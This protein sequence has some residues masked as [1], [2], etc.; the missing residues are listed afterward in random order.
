MSENTKGMDVEQIIEP[1][2]GTPVVRDVDVLVCGGGV[3]GVG[4]ALGAA[5]AGAKTMV[6]ERNAFLGGAATAVIMNT[7]NVPFHKMTGVAKEIAGALTE[8]G[9]GVVSGPTFPFDPEGFK[10]L[11]A[12]LFKAEGIEIL[13]YS[14]V[15]D[16]IMKD[17]QIRGVIIQNKSGRQAILAKTVVDAT[18]DADIAA[19]AGA[20]FV[21]GRENDAKMRPM[22]VLFRLGGVDVRRAVEFCRQNP[23]NFTADPNFH[24]LDLDTGLVRMS[25]FFDI[26]DKARANGELP[27]EIH[28]IR[29]EGVSVDR[30]IVTVNNSRVYGVDGTSGWDLTRA[31]IEARA[32]NRQLFAVIKKNI[33]GFENAFVLDS[34][35]TIGVRETRRVRGPHLLTQEDLAAHRTY[36]DSIVRIWR[37][38]A[39]GRDWHKADGGEGAP[40]DAVYRTGTTHLTWFEI[41]W[42]VLIPNGVEGMTIGGRALSATH[43]ADMWSRAQYCCLVTGQVAGAAAALAA[44]QN[45]SPSQLDVGALQKVLTEQGVDIGAVN[46]MAESVSA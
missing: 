15:V 44:R 38:M 42:G 13:T 27:D 4:A 26:V 31:D 39:E 11:T 12:E 35:P 36:P 28:Y 40:T 6:V 45:V 25:G 41:P 33:P 20:E 24:I 30:G 37:H 22:S 32:Q 14:W 16:P 18:G 1:A 46:D 3:S 23:Q 5:R 8:R 19:A 21:K 29:F 9:A 10:E 34:S 2:R 7:W 43:D 17:R